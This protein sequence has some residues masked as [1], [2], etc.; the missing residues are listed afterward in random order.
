M[1]YEDRVSLLAVAQSAKNE[2]IGKYDINNRLQAKGNKGGLG[3]VIEEG[4][5]GYAINSNKEADFAHLG[6]ELKVTPVKMLKSGKLTSKER[7]V[8]NI[9]DYMD[10]V[11]RTFGTSSFW[12]KG[13]SI[14]MMFYLWTEGVDRKD[15]PILESVLHEYSE[16]DLAILKKDWACIVSKIK[17]GLA[18]ELSEGDTMYLGAATKGSSKDSLRRQPFSDIPAM[19]RA[20]SLKSSYMKTLVDKYIN[21]E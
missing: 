18:H 2:K 14:L 21:N 1:L 12:S 4:L 19:Q 13:E 6:V 10:E 17:E 20:F 8:L 3:Q 9:I 7:L 15:Y 5:F 11:N 16:S